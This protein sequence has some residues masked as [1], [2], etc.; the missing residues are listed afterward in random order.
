METQ[1]Q[2]TLPE[3]DFKKKFQVAADTIE[4]QS[5]KK[6]SFIVLAFSAMLFLGYTE[7]NQLMKKSA[8]NSLI[9]KKQEKLLVQKIKQM[10]EKEFIH[11]LNYISK[12]VEMYD[13]KVAF[14]QKAIVRADAEEANTIETGNARLLGDALTEYKNEIKENVATLTKVRISVNND[15]EVSKDDIETFLKYLSAYQSQLILSDENIDNKIHSDIYD[16]KSGNNS[17]NQ[18]NNVYDKLKTF[19]DKIKNF[20]NEVKVEPITKVKN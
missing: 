20:F 14:V 7:S 13:E 12:N 15:V 1:K 18:K 5:Y 9:E 6:L 11:M 17:Y 2:E 8:E 10:D 16:A 3:F 19:D 4:K